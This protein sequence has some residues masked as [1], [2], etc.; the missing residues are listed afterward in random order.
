[1]LNLFLICFFKEV[2]F[3][4]FIKQNKILDLIS[5]FND[6]IKKKTQK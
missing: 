3:Y 1:M 6:I 5:I 4:F 2:L